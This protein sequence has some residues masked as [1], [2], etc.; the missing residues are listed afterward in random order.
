MLC[1][2]IAGEQQV[3][4]RARVLGGLVKLV[5]GNPS[6][7]PTS[8]PYA[9]GDGRAYTYLGYIFKPRLPN[10]KVGALSRLPL[11]DSAFAIE[12]EKDVDGVH[13]TTCVVP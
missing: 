5:Y 1:C 10:T 13:V 9:P 2:V 6:E 7:A 11:A 4:R 12:S 8:S 3:A